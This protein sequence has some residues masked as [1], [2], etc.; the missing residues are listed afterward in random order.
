D[1]AMVRNQLVYDLF[2]SFDDARYAAEGRYC[3]LVLND[4][5]RGVYRLVERPKRDRRRIDIPKDD[6]T[7]TSFIV[8][9]DPD[10]ALTFELGLEKRWTTV[11][12]ND[13]K[14]TRAQ[15][16]SVQGWFDDFS[17]VLKARSDD[18]ALFEYLDRADLVDWI[19]VQELAKNID[20]YKLSVYLYK[21]PGSPARMVPWD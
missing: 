17:K 19:L 11:Y 21:P 18:G 12:P 20:A 6:G 4:E 10:G 13:D 16:A 9:Q 14:A 5:Y 15:L 2:A 7:G 8:R 3:S 1:R